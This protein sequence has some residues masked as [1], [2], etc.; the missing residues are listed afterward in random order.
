MLNLSNFPS[1]E[2]FSH[3]PSS[4]PYEE[5]FS[6]LVKRWADL[7]YIENLFT[8]QSHGS[9]FYIDH[10]LRILPHKTDLICTR[11]ID[12]PEKSFYCITGHS[13]NKY[14]PW[15]PPMI[16]L[17][18]SYGLKSWLPYP[19]ILISKTELSKHADIGR[20]TALNFPLFGEDSMIGYFWADKE[21]NSKVICTYRHKKNHWL[22]MDT[23]KV[24]GGLPQGQNAGA[25]NRA[26]LN[27]GFD[28]DFSD[29]RKTLEKMRHD[30]VFF[31]L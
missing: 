24:H 6:L 9:D 5:S 23:S 27:M 14:L 28:A 21:E 12:P 31:T 18:A 29:C 16:E 4:P 10:D 15:W 26:I 11:W 19:C 13:L 17:F 3:F 22:L 25:D 20:R 2:Y 1:D 8:H 30:R 7:I